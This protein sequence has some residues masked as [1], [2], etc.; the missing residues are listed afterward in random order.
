M[1]HRNKLNLRYATLS[2]VA[3]IA[4]CHI[5]SW[6]KIYRG[7]MPDTLL[8]GLS[9]VERIKQWTDILRQQIKVLVLERENQIIGFASFSASRDEDTN[10]NICAEVTSFYLH[11]DVWHQGLGTILCQAVLTDIETMGFKEI[12]VWVFTAN[13]QARNFYQKMGFTETTDIKTDHIGCESLNVIRYRK[14]IERHI[15]FK[16]LQEDD[17]DMLCKWL[18]KP[19]V[20][21]WW[22]DHLTDAQIKAKYRERIGDKTVQPFIV[23]LQERPVGFI[24]SYLAD[25]VGDGWWPDVQLGTI[26]ID[27]FIGEENL[28]NRGVGTQMI[29]AFVAM[30]LEDLTVT[31]IMADVDPQNIRAVRCYKKAGFVFIKEAMTPDGYALVMEMK[32]L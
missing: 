18:N 8:D 16:P 24:Q 30:I 28:I 9:V 17:L 19:H 5:I 12:I 1:N 29:R 11:P 31:T 23:Y 7:L 26:G 25:K 2:D 27:Q 10:S 13:Q 22:D 14:K 6:Q 15:T 21:E 4:N 20:K 3:Q 32:R